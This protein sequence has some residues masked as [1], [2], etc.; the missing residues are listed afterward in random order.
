[1]SE[2]DDGVDE[3]VRRYFYLSYARPRAS[4]TTITP[5]HWVKQFYEDLVQHIR[6]IIGPGKTPIGF[7]DVGLPADRDRQAEIQAALASADV[8]VALYSQ[9][10]LV[11]REARIDRATFMGRLAS[12]ASGMPAEKHILP[13]LWAP[14]PG[15]FYRAEVADARRFAEDVPEYVMNGLSVLCRIST[16][17]EQYERVLSRMAQEI[18]RIADRFP[19]VATQSVDMVEDYRVRVWPTAPFTIAVLA[20]TSGDLPL[21]DGRGPAH[22]YGTRAE[23]WKPFAG[24][25]AVADEVAAEADR[26]RLPVDV[27]GYTA[28]DSMYRDFPGMI[29]IDPWILATP[30]GRD[31]VR[32]TLRCPYSWVTIAAVVDEHHPR[33][34]PHGTRYLSQ[35]EQ[36]LRRTDRFIR[37][38]TVASWR[39]EM[40]EIVSRMRREYMNNGPSYAPTSPSGARPRLGRPEAGRNPPSSS[41]GEQ[42]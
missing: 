40:P 17:R 32:S 18:V 20:P 15:N 4:A 34:E 33:F 5:D 35:L 21:S 30:G 41:E 11:S 19:L 6:V 31:L 25:H 2:P 8:F 38:T 39:S 26:L 37:F 10:Y 28:D 42:A 13:V 29:L 9:K 7:A 14:L 12:A 1:V 36:L 23:H 22:G 27:V 3:P 24:G 16:F